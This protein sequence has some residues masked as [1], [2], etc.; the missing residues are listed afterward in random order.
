MKK[1]L[2]ALFAAGLAFSVI[3]QEAPAKTEGK[4]PAPKCEK[5]RRGPHFRK[6]GPSPEQKAQ[7]EN[8]GKLKAKYAKE[9]EEIDT[10]RK[11]GWKQ[12]ADANAKFFELAEKEGLDVP[13]LKQWQ[14]GKKM[15][16][17][18][19]KYEKEL[20][21]IRELRKT[22]PKAAHEKMMELFK[23][24]GIEKPAFHKGPRKGPEGPECRGPRKGPKGPCNGK[25]PAC[26][27]K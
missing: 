20:K 1:L 13:G 27:K 26:D 6:P 21:D 18:F 10:M 9:M 23:K 5:G 7:W 2:T 3:A 17:F 11:A 8:V 19:Q 25:K 15:K 22:D 14:H 24:E 4:C 12:I 16:A